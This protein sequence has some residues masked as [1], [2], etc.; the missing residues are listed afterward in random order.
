M[1]ALAEAYGTVDDRD[2]WERGQT[3]AS[4]RSI[5]AALELAVRCAV[6]SQKKNPYGGWRYAPDA[7]DADTSVSGAS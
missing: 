2:L 6:T 3:S 5:G 1:L 4:Q 7:R